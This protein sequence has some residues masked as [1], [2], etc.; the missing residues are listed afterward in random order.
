MNI[1]RLLF[2]VSVNVDFMCRHWVR[3][4]INNLNEGF[5]DSPLIKNYH[6]FA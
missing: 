5:N 2:D 4:K 3:I 6:L 1:H